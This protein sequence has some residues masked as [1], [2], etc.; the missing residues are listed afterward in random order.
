MR[1]VFGISSDSWMCRSPSAVSILRLGSAGH[2][3][4]LMIPAGNKLYGPPHN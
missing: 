1:V 3:E 2:F 4:L